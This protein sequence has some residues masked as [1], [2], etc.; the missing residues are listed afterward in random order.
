M[1]YNNIRVDFIKVS[2][3]EKNWNLMIMVYFS[4]DFEL[5]YFHFKIMHGCKSS[6]YKSDCFAVAPSIPPTVSYTKR[7]QANSVEGE[8]K[9]EWDA[10]R[11]LPSSSSKGDMATSPL[12][13]QERRKSSTAS[14]VR[15][16]GNHIMCHCCG[17]QLHMTNNSPHILSL[18]LICVCAGVNRIALVEWPGEI[19]TYASDPVQSGTQPS[20]T[21]KTAGDQIQSARFHTLV[22]LIYTAK[23]LKLKLMWNYIDIDLLARWF[24]QQKHRPIRY[25]LLQ[26]SPLCLPVWL[27][28]NLC[29]FSIAF[30]PS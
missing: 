7:S 24:F 8:K 3:F 13:A 28:P 5:T 19:H 17:I 6:E 14:G 23:F 2:V 10:S 9:E 1:L 29:L 26:M 18:W 15:G 20:L 25:K 30:S 16:H 11:K 4:F 12:V 21:A 27:L 22:F